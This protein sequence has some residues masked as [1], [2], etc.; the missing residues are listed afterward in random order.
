MVSIN[1]AFKE[2]SCKIVYYG[3]GLSGKTTNLQYVHKKVPQPTKGELISLATDAD[4]TLYFDF[5]PI[6]IGSVAGFTTKFQL[7]TVP[8][9]V[10]YNATRKLVLRGADGLVFVADSQESKMEENQESLKNL[11]DNLQE[12]GYNLNE[13]PMVIQYNERDLPGALPLDVLEKALNPNGLLSFEA[14]AVKG[15]GVF[16]TLKCIIKIVLENA[17]AKSE[18]GSKS[19]EP[20]SPQPVRQEMP[21]RAEHNNNEER[22]A[23]VS[24]RPKME[25]VGVTQPDWSAPSAGEQ[26]RPVPGLSKLAP[27][28]GPPEPH[29]PVVV[30]GVRQ[31]SG[32]EV[33]QSARQAVERPKP[34][35]SSQRLAVT[36]PE[37]NLKNRPV[38]RPNE[39]ARGRKEEKK[40]S[41]FSRLFG[42]FKK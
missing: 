12:Y 4:R 17:R 37:F 36:R 18:T 14:V 33:K 22:P 26:F 16:D 34:L 11:L 1:Y 25:P 20:P 2:I 23:A 39:L 19:A 15:D 9:Q 3:P 7:Y 27:A 13:V 41:F 21:E 42:I 5:L 38:L 30:P 32:A 8:G 31:T 10:Y 35:S 29:R 28:P 6:N 24:Q 40:K